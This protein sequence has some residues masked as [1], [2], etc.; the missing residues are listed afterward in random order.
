MT[1]R[2]VPTSAQ[3]EEMHLRLRR[4]EI[5]PARGLAAVP[6]DR[7]PQDVACRTAH[8]T[9]ARRRARLQPAGGRAP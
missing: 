9:H 2:A 5:S 4:T 7:P 1:I 8:S 6:G 3:R